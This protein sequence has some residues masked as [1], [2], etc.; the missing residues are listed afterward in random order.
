MVKLF[1][2]FFKKRWLGLTLLLIL[3]SLS[4]PLVLKVRVDFD[5]LRLLETGSSA[6]ST[7]Q[8]STSAISSV[9]SRKV[10]QRNRPNSGYIE[11]HDQR[12]K[13]IG[14]MVSGLNDSRLSKH[15]SYAVKKKNVESAGYTDVRNHKVIIVY[16]F[17]S[18]QDTVLSG[19]YLRALSH[20]QNQIKAMY[21]KAHVFTLVGV[22]TPEV[23][24]WTIFRKIKYEP[25]IG[26]L[27]MTPNER[28]VVMKRIKSSYPILRDFISADLKS[29]TMYIKYPA[30]STVD[31]YRTYMG[32]NHIIQ[33]YKPYFSQITHMSHLKSRKY[34]WL[35]V[36][37][38][39]PIY[40]LFILLTLCVMVAVCYKRM[41]YGVIL[42]F[43]N[44]INVFFIAAVMGFAQWPLNML[45]LVIP[46]IVVVVG[47]TEVI[48]L[49]NAFHTGLNKFR[50]S[51]DRAAVYMVKRIGVA[52][53]L[54]AITTCFGLYTFAFSNS[55]AVREFGLVGGTSMLISGLTS[56]FIL[57]LLLGAI[58]RRKWVNSVKGSRKSVVGVWE[59]IANMVVNQRVVVG[60]CLVVLTGVISYF[61]LSVK[62]DLHTFNTFK[63]DH[64][65]TQEVNAF[66]ED[67]GGVGKMNV[68]ITS[69]QGEVFTDVDNLYKVIQ[70]NRRMESYSDV[71]SVIDYSD[72]VMVV[73]NKINKRSPDSFLRREDFTKKDQSLIDDIKGRV[74]KSRLEKLMINP[75]FNRIHLMVRYKVDSV[76]T[77]E[78]VKA[79]VIDA[80]R[81]C[82]G[83]DLTVHVTYKNE[84]KYSVFSHLFVESVYSVLLCALILFLFFSIYWRSIIIGFFAF[85]PNVLS[86]I[87]LLGYMGFSHMFLN[88]ITFSSFVVV[89]SVGVDFSVH[90]YADYRRQSILIKD[91]LQL[92]KSI[93]G[94][95]VKPLFISMMVIS[96]P[97][98]MMNVASNVHF[99][100]VCS[101]IGVGILS[102]FVFNVMCSSL[103]FRYL[104]VRKA[105]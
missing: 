4:V 74:K 82:L 28:D 7:G 61:S 84:K 51:V 12:K 63:S 17:S 85:I 87:A 31:A 65:Y 1:L 14:F 91:K 59:S 44:F 62:Y 29:S 93:L 73:L 20:C 60:V 79:H 77:S 32:M 56:L 54:T 48:H 86:L 99:S 78:R 66:K 76:L 81:S 70:F 8:L 50:G 90:L 49:L 10:S 39:L 57:P 35:F 83:N 19:V 101:L 98:L 15:R 67:F 80:V 45:C 97:M 16:R 13:N 89:L 25:L 69:P 36:T 100:H 42:L 30:S 52:C 2:I 53:V 103:V 3:L 55:L 64:P 46:I 37:K 11:K 105:T 68:T 41:S 24:G 71:D 92:T 43:L 102:S 33:S 9:F 21:K 75:D 34:D 47:S 22:K 26:K 27:N 6:R 72:L 23:S 38:E 88:S 18:K 94:Y 104:R 58:P 40:C 5:Y 95:Q 96:I